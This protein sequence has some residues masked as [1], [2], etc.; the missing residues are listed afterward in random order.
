MQRTEQ[1]TE[2]MLLNIPLNDLKEIDRLLISGKYSTKSEVVRTALKEFLYSK[3]RMEKF[4]DFAK[5]VQARVK[6]L[7]LTKE[8][9]DKA[10]EEAK[11]GTRR[12]VRRMLKELHEK[13]RRE[14]PVKRRSG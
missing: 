9:I 13:E 11:E 1:K 6:E 2:K 10:I 14:R 12:D 3:E 5:E 7:K 4:D 8:D